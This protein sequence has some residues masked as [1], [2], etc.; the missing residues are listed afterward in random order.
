MLRHLVILTLL[1]SPTLPLRAQQAEAAD[2]IQDLYS[3]FADLDETDEAEWQEACELLSAL[4][5][6]PRN[7]NAVSL[8][9]LLQIPFVDERQAQAFMHYRSLYGDLSSMAELQL[10]TALDRP[11][12]QLLAQLFYAAP[13]NGDSSRQ[14]NRPDS[15]MPSGYRRLPHH[16]HRST[17]L[18]TLH[19]P[20]YQRQGYTD[21]TYHGYPVKHS[22]RFV[23]NGRHL[24][25]ALTASQDAGEPFFAGTN[26]AGWDFYTGYVQ[27]K[28][29]GALKNLVAGHYQM[30]MGMGLIM[31][32]AYRPSR[33]SLLLSMPTP[34]LRLRGHTSSQQHNYLQGVAATVAI[35]GTSA[36]TLTA[37]ASYRPLD[38]T[39]SATT[40]PTVTTILTT[41]YHRT[42]TEILRRNATRQTAA[43]GSLSLWLGKVQM[44]LNMV[45]VAMRDTLRPDL[46]QRHR[47]YAPTGLR[48]TNLSAS[49]SYATPRLRIGGETAM[50]SNTAKDD[51]AA[52][53]TMNALQW[54]PRKGLTLFAVERFYSYRYQTLLG[55]SFGDVSDVRNES[56]IYVGAT[57]V[58]TRKLH[59]S[60]YVDYAYHPWYR[61]GWDGS[62]QTGDAALTATYT[63]GGTTATLRY[64][65]HGQ[66]L[67]SEGNTDDD[68]EQ[69]R[70]TTT[71]KHKAGRWSLTTQ[72]LGTVLPRSADWGWALSQGAGYAVGTLSLWASLGYFHS[73]S[74]ASRLYL[75]DRNLTY[76]ALSTM[77]YGKGIRGSA[78]AQMTLWRGITAAL[79][80]SLLH[81]FD[82]DQIS[83]GAQM[84]PHSSQTDLGIQ[85][86]AKF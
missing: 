85:I 57:V 29:T 51:G 62:S 81:Y 20:T 52:L 35:P 63:D 77:V 66:W 78:M 73:S 64:R 75:T 37:F 26:K 25:A 43:G 18:F 2:G 49:Y 71:L 42:D 79:H 44:A 30:T 68:T 11:R 17:L 3:L 34:T 24:S 10:V 48:F 36:L 1:L 4:A 53:A 61:Y 76:G 83:S 27:M 60:A 45:H 19:L 31:N 47:W 70:L 67:A 39:M 55:R 50:C 59:L 21:G 12:Q 56:G 22:V 33:S 82:R 38:A 28:N 23:H 41:G 65:Y 15:I 6:T 9:D 5:E 54:L 69:H 58:P 16:Q 32:T 8:D 40:V 84:I 46:S 72:A 14:R 86:R 7:I 74:Y 80:C 13:T